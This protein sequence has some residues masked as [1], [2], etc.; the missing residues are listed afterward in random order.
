[1]N[2][3]FDLHH[4]QRGI[5]LSLVARS[6]LKFSELQPPRI[7]NNTFSYHLRKLLENGYIE[8]TQSGYIPTR[9]S[10]KLIAINGDQKW[11]AS[12]PSLITMFYV[13]N[14]E[15]EVLLLNRNIE[16]FQGWYSLPSG[17]IHTGETLLEAAE[18]ELYE[19][20]GIKTDALQPIG[21]LDFQYREESTEDL[22]VHALA[23]LFSFQYIGDKMSMNDKSTRFG[24][25]SWSKLGRQHILPE[26]NAV[27]DIA[28]SA[29]YTQKSIRF[30]EPSHKPILSLVGHPATP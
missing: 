18:R 26:V 10:L 24:Q 17:A 7:P 28:E 27:R 14:D 20:T 1:M 19:K 15:G 25:L 2:Q 12:S 9:K 4:I 3:R 13:T 21:V 16:P 8:Q 11:R 22:F 29:T 5:I 6:P 30:V 23:F